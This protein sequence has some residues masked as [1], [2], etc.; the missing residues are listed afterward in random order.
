MAKLTKCTKC[1]RTIEEMEGRYNYPS[2][3]MCNECGDEKHKQYEGKKVSEVLAKELFNIDLPRN[4][5]I[6]NYNEKLASDLN[7]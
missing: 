4:V 7:A 3:V 1:G 6:N 2:G 5:R